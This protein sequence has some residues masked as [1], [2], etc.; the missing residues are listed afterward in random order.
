MNLVALQRAVEK[1]KGVEGYCQ[2]VIADLEY[3]LQFGS[4]FA[5]SMFICIWVKAVNI[6]EDEVDYY[7]TIKGI[8][9]EINAS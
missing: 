4:E 7:N 2:E 6:R 1:R 3:G 9:E 5:I 8:S